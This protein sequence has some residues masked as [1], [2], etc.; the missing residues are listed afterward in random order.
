MVSLG[1]AEIDGRTWVAPGSV[2]GTNGRFLLKTIPLKE[3]YGS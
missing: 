2:G 3:Q 1:Q